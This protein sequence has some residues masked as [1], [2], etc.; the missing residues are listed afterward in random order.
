MD[1][2][3]WLKSKECPRPRRSELDCKGLRVF[4]IPCLSWLAQN[5][6]AQYDFRFMREVIKKGHLHVAKWL[7]T[8]HNV[9]V[10]GW[11]VEDALQSRDITM[12]DWVW[13]KL[14]PEQLTHFKSK[15]PE[16][17]STTR[18]GQFDVNQFY[19]LCGSSIR[20]Y[21][22]LYSH[23][24]APKKVI[25]SVPKIQAK[26]QD[27]M[28]DCLRWFVDHG[29]V[30]TDVG[31]EY[32]AAMSRNDRATITLLIEQGC[33]MSYDILERSVISGQDLSTIKY[34]CQT[35]SERKKA[36][37]K[38]SE[39]ESWLKTYVDAVYVE[40][41]IPG[42][43]L[44]DMFCQALMLKRWTVASWLMIQTKGSCLRFTHNHSASK[45]FSR[46]TDLLHPYLS[47][48]SGQPHDAWSLEIQPLSHLMMYIYT[49]Y[50]SK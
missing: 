43:E 5:L 32:V 50:C 24:F 13:S 17:E 25:L 11:A 44:M 15:S 27:S 47:S 45:S 1:I 38:V 49:L 19:K 36:L 35:L 20:M 22:W 9:E 2:L 42:T 6:G 14:S 33:P 46:L 8:V 18:R 7:N 21:E 40:I 30:W 28:L 41:P 39:Y 3:E 31:D 26:Y 34:M 23:G 37:T 10:S 12:L 16:P 4:D 48:I 29:A